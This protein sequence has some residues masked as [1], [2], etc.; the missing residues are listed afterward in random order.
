LA[1]RIQLCVGADLKLSQPPR[2]CRLSI[3]RASLREKTRIL[4][5]IRRLDRFIET[6]NG[7]LRDECLNVHW[8]E[9]IDDAKPKIAAWRHEYNESPPHQA[10]LERTPAEFARWA[11]T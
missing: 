5:S 10:L 6:F 1:S 11:K 4:R 2:P 9:S 3:D 7:S 8:F